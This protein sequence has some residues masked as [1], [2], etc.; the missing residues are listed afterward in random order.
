MEGD[1]FEQHQF[2]D[3]ARQVRSNLHGDRPTE[4]M[5]N[6]TNFVSAS[7]EGGFDKARLVGQRLSRAASEAS[8]H[9]SE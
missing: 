4:R 8:C 7:R 9:I 2:R 3:A 6:D 5:T 1:G